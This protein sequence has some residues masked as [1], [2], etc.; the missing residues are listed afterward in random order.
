MDATIEDLETRIG[1]DLKILRT[2]R[3]LTIDQLATASGVSR[4]MI[5]RIERGE[6]NPTAVLLA[7]L[8]APL[9]QSLSDFFALSEKAAAASPLR[10]FEDQATWQDPQTG[11]VR[12]SVSPNGF[13]T[14][15]DI[16]EVELP[17]GA[18]VAF[19][20]LP[21]VHKHIQYIWLLEGVLEME[22]D[23][24]IQRMAPGDCLFMT[25]KSRDVFLNPSDQSCRYAV[26][27]KK[28]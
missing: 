10:R 16:I 9:D 5:S 24:A 13:N 23:G 17:A 2:T 4:A 19:D 28:G 25:L 11:Y 27:L 14:D 22:A 7:R 20:P 6:T 15:V 3:G 18:R 21:A 1:D 26:V 12:R 8:L